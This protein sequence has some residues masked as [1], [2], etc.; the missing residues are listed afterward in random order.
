MEDYEYIVVKYL[1]DEP[2]T[3]FSFDSYEKAARYRDQ[4]SIKEYKNKFV[5]YLIEIRTKNKQ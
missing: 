4:M 1:C 3:E 5:Y 2:E